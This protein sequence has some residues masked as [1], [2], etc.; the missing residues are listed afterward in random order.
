MALASPILCRYP[1][2]IIIKKTIK[3]CW[4]IL[5]LS[6]FH[7]NKNYWYHITLYITFSVGYSHSNYPMFVIKKIIKNKNCLFFCWGVFNNNH[8]QQKNVY[9][10]V[11]FSWD[12]S[13]RSAMCQILY[14]DRYSSNMDIN[15]FQYDPNLR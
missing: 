2:V 11:F 8:Y 13:S 5:H 6:L 4:N 3:E 14:K 9:F 12:R 15:Y 10:S 7:I 1:N